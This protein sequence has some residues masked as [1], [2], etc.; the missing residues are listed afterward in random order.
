MALREVSMV[1]SQMKFRAA[2]S[3]VLSIAEIKVQEDKILDH[4]RQDHCGDF[5]KFDAL[6]N[7]CWSDPHGFVTID[8]TSNKANGNECGLVKLKCLIDHDDCSG[9]NYNYNFRQKP[10][11][12]QCDFL[13]RNHIYNFHQKPKQSKCSVKTVRGSQCPYPC[14]PGKNK[15]KRHLN[16]ESKKDRPNCDDNLTPCKEDMPEFVKVDIY[17]PKFVKL[18]SG[19]KIRSEGY[20]FLKDV[21]RHFNE[22][23]CKEDMPEFVTCYQCGVKVDISMPKFIILIL[24]IT[25]VYLRSGVKIGIEGYDFLEDVYRYFNKPFCS[26]DCLEDITYKGAWGRFS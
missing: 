2:V 25:I 13:G 19:V 10:K 26:S 21:Y 16:L 18:W 1:L 14:K 9:R 17:I 22:P 3:F 4:I 12:P 7:H 6:R 11:Q 24:L 5:T 8:I 20:D 23:P 15:C